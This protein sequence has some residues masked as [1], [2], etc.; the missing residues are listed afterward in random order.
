MIKGSILCFLIYI[1]LIFLYNMNFVISYRHFIKIFLLF[2][3]IFL[4]SWMPWCRKFSGLWIVC[5]QLIYYIQINWSIKNIIHNA[6]QSLIT[7]KHD[8]MIKI[9]ESDHYDIFCYSWIYQ[10]RISNIWWVAL[11]LSAWT[12]LGATGESIS[13]VGIIGYLSK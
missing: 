11:I 4:R 2:L 1:W 6:T 7:Q 5:C 10:F 8:P 13:L 9:V 3:Q 12:D